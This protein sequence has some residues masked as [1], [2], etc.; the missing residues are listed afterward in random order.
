[1]VRLID[2]GAAFVHAY[3]DATSAA[4]S[5]VLKHQHR[6]IALGVSAAHPH[7]LSSGK[8]VASD[9]PPFHCGG[10]QCM[11]LSVS[12]S[13]ACTPSYERLYGMKP[14]KIEALPRNVPAV[15]LSVQRRFP[16]SL[17][18]AHAASAAAFEA[19]LNSLIS[20]QPSRVRLP[21]GAGRDRDL[22]GGRPERTVPTATQTRGRRDARTCGIPLSGW[23]WMR[24][25]W[26]D[27]LGGGF[28][29]GVGLKQTHSPR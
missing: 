13:K 17:C 28:I 9:L 2:I 4:F 21:C 12:M 22:R 23:I 3:G 5:F 24:M 27:V 11:S 18:G 16:S 15:H 10:R 14:V 6:G 20:A 19:A 26:G 1:M 25:G 7:R 29:C 8:I